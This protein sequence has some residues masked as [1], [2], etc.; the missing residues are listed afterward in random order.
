MKGIFY[1]D[2]F[3]KEAVLSSTKYTLILKPGP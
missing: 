3:T 1:K 2:H